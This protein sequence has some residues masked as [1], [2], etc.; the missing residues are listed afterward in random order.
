MSLISWSKN[1][2]TGIASIDEQHRILLEILNTVHAT[3]V[4]SSEGDLDAAFQR[5]M[6]YTQFHFAHEE[7]LFEQHKYPFAKKHAQ[8][9]QKLKSDAEMRISEYKG[10]K[11]GMIDILAFL[12][13]WLQ[14]H[15]VNS[16]KKFGNFIAMK[17]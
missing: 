6:D 15:I 8:E 10:G 11:I 4:G 7:K 13:D 12:I 17:H 14:E 3:M 2:E 5:L 1:L 9:H 16:D